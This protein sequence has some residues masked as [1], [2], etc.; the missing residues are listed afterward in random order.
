MLGA[1]IGGCSADSTDGTQS[2]RVKAPPLALPEAK[3]E[4]ALPATPLTVL[5]SV[6]EVLV[7]VPEG[8]KDPFAPF[9]KRT[10]EPE[11]GDAGERDWEVLGVLSVDDQLRAL[12]STAE[13]SG[14]VCLGAG[15]RCPGEA[16]QL[17]PM[18]LEVQAINIRTGCLTV[19][20][21]GKSEPEPV[22][23]T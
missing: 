20:Q 5:P 8:R 19:L 15:G 11:L 22:C 4:S 7:A 10:P 12:I 17:F 21:S 23:I 13:G 6:G 9:P 18:D 14:T 1:L 2:N 16:Q 3:V